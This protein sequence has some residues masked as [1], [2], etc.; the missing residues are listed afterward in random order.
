MITGQP[1][2]CAYLSVAFRRQELEP[3]AYNPE[4]RLLFIPSIEGCNQVFTEEQKDF[5]DQGGTVTPRTVSPAAH[6]DGAATLR[7]PQALDPV[8]GDTKAH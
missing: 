4:L 7:Q 2:K 1:T 6:Q 5:I 3:S 8:T